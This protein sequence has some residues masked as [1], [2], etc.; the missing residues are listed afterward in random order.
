[1]RVDTGALSAGE[2]LRVIPHQN[3]HIGS[4]GP[5]VK[6]PIFDFQKGPLFWHCELLDLRV[7][8]G[9]APISRRKMLFLP[10]PTICSTLVGVSPTYMGQWEPNIYQLVSM[11]GGILDISGTFVCPLTS[12]V[13][14]LRFGGRKGLRIGQSGGAFACPR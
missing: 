3:W 7:P 6:Y 11:F 14:W 13:W 4:G 9:S 8:S 2:L 5:E 1:M 10:V 12:P